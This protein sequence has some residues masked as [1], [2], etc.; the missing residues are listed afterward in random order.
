MDLVSSSQQ[1]IIF[2]LISDIKN[3]R[4]VWVF[5]AMSHSWKNPWQTQ[6]VQQVNSA[7]ANMPNH[8]R[9][10]PHL[11]KDPPFVSLLPNAGRIVSLLLISGRFLKFLSKLF[12]KTYYFQFCPYK[13]WNMRHLPNENC[14]FSHTTISHI[15]RAFCT[16]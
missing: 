14:L 8:Y 16:Q 11:P 15:C 12:G 13:S 2:C 5:S 6:D 1:I 10:G 4:K 9:F 7:K 3:S